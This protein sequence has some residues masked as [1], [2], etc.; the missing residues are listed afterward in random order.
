MTQQAAAHQL[1]PISFVQVSK[2]SCRQ[3][4]SKEFLQLPLKE[5]REASDRSVAPFHTDGSARHIANKG[6]MT[7]SVGTNRR[8]RCSYQPGQLCDTSNP[9]LFAMHSCF[10][11]SAVAGTYDFV[12]VTHTV[13][14]ASVSL[15][16]MVAVHSGV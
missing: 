3:C 14:Y 9:T 7:D 15:I 8:S 6:C 16:V 1:A 11:G 10:C 4:S 2:E 12:Q 5:L 13:V